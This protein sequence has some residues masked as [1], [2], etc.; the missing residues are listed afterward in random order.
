MRDTRALT[1]T[2][3]QVYC[4]QIC[5][6]AVW[7]YIQTGL[8]APFSLA[9]MEESMCEAFPVRHSANDYDEKRIPHNC[10]SD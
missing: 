8:G 4:P 10:T 1:S 9:G 3:T 5:F 6:K 7:P 2:E